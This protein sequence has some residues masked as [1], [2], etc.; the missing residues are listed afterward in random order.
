MRYNK[1]SPSGAVAI[2][3]MI[4]DYPDAMPSNSSSA[5]STS[6]LSSPT[7]TLFGSLSPP[8][9]PT[10]ASP[11]LTPIRQANPLPS[12][13][14]GIQPPPQRN[15]LLP[16]P[17]VHPAS[18]SGIKTTYTPYV[19]RSRARR[20]T[21]G[22]PPQGVFNAT[23]KAVQNA[24]LSPN[25]LSATGQQV[26]I[27]TS[28]AQG[29]VTTRHA[30]PSSPL[31]MTSSLSPAPGAPPRPSADQGPSAALLEKVRALDSLPRLGELR[32]LDLRGNDI[33]VRLHVSPLH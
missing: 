27:I 20:A 25:P 24:T 30:A 8:S 28:S 1:I 18:V 33:K 6:S 23:V 3:L 22:A 29:G 15:H 14:S 32:T 17:P 26:P 4:K 5:S 9:T 13:A 31:S 12:L 11:P 21:P 16:P 7:S 10:T 2:A 19:P